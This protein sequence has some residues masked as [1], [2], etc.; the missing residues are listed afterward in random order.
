MEHTKTVLIT[1]TEAEYQELENIS[2][3][4]GAS[5]SKIVSQAL[6]QFSDSLKGVFDAMDKAP[7]ST[8]PEG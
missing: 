5:K 8:F 7:C 1:L 6:L 4:L 3:R 2:C